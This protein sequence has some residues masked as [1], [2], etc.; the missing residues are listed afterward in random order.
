MRAGFGRSSARSGL[1]GR[2]SARNAT[3][4]QPR[5]LPARN[6]PGWRH[7]VHRGSARGAKTIATIRPEALRPRLQSLVGTETSLSAK[8]SRN[9]SREKTPRA[10]SPTLPVEGGLLAVMPEGVI[11]WARRPEEPERVSRVSLLANDVVIGSGIAD[12]FD[13]EAVRASVG[14]GVPGFLIE[15]SFL[16]NGPFPVAFLVRDADGTPLGEPLLVRRPEQFGALPRVSSDRSS[17]YEGMVEG[18]REGQLVGWIRSRVDPANA[19]VVELFDG[20]E[21]RGPT[22]C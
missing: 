10:L 17:Q 12:R 14:P 11:G 7:V 15:P 3:G 19:V 2:G 18:L 8:L 6:S 1:S 5:T 21:S 16:P 9:N 20:V 13:I 4:P 22:S